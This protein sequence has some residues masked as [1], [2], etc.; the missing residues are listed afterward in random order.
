M[1]QNNSFLENESQT[2]TQTDDFSINYEEELPV[3]VEQPLSKGTFNG[4]LLIVWGC[5]EFG[6]HGHGHSDDVP[7]GDA[8]GCPLWLGEVDR[9]VV[10][11]ACGSS[12]TMVLTGQFP[13]NRVSF[14]RYLKEY[15]SK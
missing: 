13:A 15:A 9:M 6:Q 2:E 4:G 10:E 11:V 1:L 5:G 14:F 7:I 12:H 3:I 8:L